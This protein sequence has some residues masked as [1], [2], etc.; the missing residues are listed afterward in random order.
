M[1]P[2]YRHIIDRAGIALMDD[3]SLTITLRGYT[4]PFGTAEGR[5]EL[6]LARAKVCAEYLKKQ[7]GIPESRMKIE[8]YGAEKTPEFKDASWESYRC[9]ELLLNS[10]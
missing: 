3:P 6:S 4:A 9:V 5:T 7:Y 8:H 1:I 10:N 2:N